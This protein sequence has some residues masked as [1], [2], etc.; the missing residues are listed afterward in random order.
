VAATPACL[1]RDHPEEAVSSGDLGDGIINNAVMVRD[2]VPAQ[3][4]D[5]VRSLL[6]DSSE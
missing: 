4:R 1:Q 5:S 3:I 2:D 6:L